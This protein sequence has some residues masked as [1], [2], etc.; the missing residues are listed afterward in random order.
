MVLIAGGTYTYARVPLG[1]WLQPAFAFERNPYDKIGHFMQGVVPAL[2]AREIFAWRICEGRKD[3]GV[4]VG[5]RG[6]GGKCVL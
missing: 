3:G 1:A 4:T 6:H 5:V 2:V